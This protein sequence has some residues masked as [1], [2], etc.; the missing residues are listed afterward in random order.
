MADGTEGPPPPV[1]ELPSASDVAMLLEVVMAA[2]LLFEALSPKDA[3]K[4]GVRQQHRDL[5][6]TLARLHA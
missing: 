3:L 2:H 4:V 5:G 6:D 1:H